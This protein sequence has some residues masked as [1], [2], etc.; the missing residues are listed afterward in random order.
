MKIYHIDAFTSK[1]FAGNPA[2]VCLDDGSAKDDWMQQV[3][4]EMNLS[5][6]AFVH[7]RDDG[8]SLRW[9]TP[10]AEVPLCGHATLASAH[11]LWE[12]GTVQGDTIR[13]HTLSGVLHARRHD[14][15]I[16]IDLPA[17]ELEEHRLPQSTRKALGIDPLWC[18]RTPPR[19]LGDRDVLVE[20]ESE[21]VVRA[22]RP[23]FREL[24]RE[25]KAGII[26]TASSGAAEQDF[27]SRYFA[28][29][30]GIDEDP[31][32]GA[33]HCALVPFWARKLDKSRLIGYQASARGGLVHGRLQ[34]DRV[35]LSGEAVTVMEGRLNLPGADR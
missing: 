33:A 19:G 9:F 29:W 18:G 17:A 24:R 6:T 22:A 35:L 8:F 3:A 27:V 31:V 12:S 21:A 13:F 1:P 11:A 16:E 4:M 23:D 25:P 7:A 26:I 32:T 5:E 15:R 10:E 30:W 2:A 28:P 20:L 14:G 34:G